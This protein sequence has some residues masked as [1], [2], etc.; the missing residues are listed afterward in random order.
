MK[1]KRRGQD[2]FCVTKLRKTNKKENMSVELLPA[3]QPGEN[4]APLRDTT[5]GGAKPL[6]RFINGEPQV[7]GIIVLIL[8]I[9]FI[10][11]AIV[12]ERESMHP[13]MWTAIQPGYVIGAMFVVCGI[14]YIITEHNPT[15]KTVTISLA[16]SIVAILCSI[17]TAIMVIPHIERLGYDRIYDTFED[18]NTTFMDYHTRYSLSPAAVVEQVL[19][20]VFMFYV[21]VGTVLFIVMS[22]LA[23]AALRSSRTK[24]IVVMSTTSNATPAEP[25]DEQ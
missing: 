12:V 22:T 17:W 1:R 14:V 15:K 18:E 11:T 9:S 3:R 5:V 24:A 23:T 16:L 25:Q 13:E 4:N 2:L 7:V 20:M 10:I 21:F 6:H 19:D 8:G